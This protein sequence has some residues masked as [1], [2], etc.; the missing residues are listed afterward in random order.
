MLASMG[1]I[2]GLLFRSRFLIKEPDIHRQ[3]NIVLWG[4]IL[5][6]APFFIFTLL[7]IIIFGTGHEYLDG[8]YSVLFLIFIPVSYAYTIFQ[9][10]ILKIDFLVNRLV[11]FF[12]LAMFVLLV[13]VATLGIFAI[14]T[15]I[16]FSTILG[17]VSGHYVA[18]GR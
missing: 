8:N 17:T 16:A 13:S 4:T 1:A 7:P 15:A 18:R 11:V 10:K 6:F 12:V 3:T 9:R 5:G 14:I 2:V